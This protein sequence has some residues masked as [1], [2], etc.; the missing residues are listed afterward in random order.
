MSAPAM[1]V[2]R[3]CPRRIPFGNPRCP[4]CATRYERERAADPTR[5]PLYSEAWRCK[6]RA[7]RRAQPWCSVRGCTSTDLTLDHVTARA[8]GGS[9]DGPTRVLCRYHNGL[10]GAG[11]GEELTY[12]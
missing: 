3:D 2:C 11:D 5:R 4:E 9:N 10:K 7:A 12:R 6:S 8:W 1:R